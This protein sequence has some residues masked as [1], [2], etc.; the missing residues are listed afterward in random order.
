MS[1]AVEMVSG[2]MIYMLSF[3]KIDTGVRKLLR[4]IH[5]RSKVRKVS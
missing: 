4:G 2:G 3:M 1:H 5:T